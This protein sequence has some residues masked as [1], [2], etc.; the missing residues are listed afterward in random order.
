[1]GSNPQ[2]QFVAKRSI[3]SE[4]LEKRFEDADRN[5][6]D[7]YSVSCSPSPQF[8]AC[9]ISDVQQHWVCKTQS[10]FSSLNKSYAARVHVRHREQNDT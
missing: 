5:C 7:A 4:L 8:D 6:I 1:M 10:G 3:F 2:P 9:F